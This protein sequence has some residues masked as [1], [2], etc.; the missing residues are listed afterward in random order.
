M[1][2]RQIRAGYEPPV[3]LMSVVGGSIG[4]WAS[5]KPTHTA[6]AR[7]GVYPTKVASA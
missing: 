1:T 7:W 3:T 6:A 5:G 2:S 4:I